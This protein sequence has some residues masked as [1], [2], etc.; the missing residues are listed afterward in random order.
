MNIRAEFKQKM[1]RGS[2]EVVL[3]PLCLDPFAAILARR[4]GFDCVYVGGGG[5]G[6]ALG[7]SEAL[8]EARDV[9]EAARRIGERVEVAVVVD[10]GVGFGD[11]IHTAHAVR[12]IEAAGAAAV[13]LEDQVAPKRAHHHKGVEHLVSTEEMC[14]KLEAAVDARRDGDFVIIARCNAPQ[15]E[16]MERALE[17]ARAY[18]E[19]G[20]DVLMLR[21][22]SDAEFGQISRATSAPLATLASWTLKPDAEM[23]AAGYTLVMDPNS[24]TVLA[25]RALTAAFESMRAGRGVGLSREAVLATMQEVMQAI[26]LEELYAIEAATT[27]KE[28][29]APLPRQ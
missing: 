12:L 7:V 14:G 22:R 19:A 10:G 4:A 18:Q 29:P 5:L 3:A 28:T 23:A 1:R 27:E 24:A 21:A 6:Y 11:A 26:G 9:A 20:A 17:R 13:E 8:L 25:Y 2:G 15:I 16:G